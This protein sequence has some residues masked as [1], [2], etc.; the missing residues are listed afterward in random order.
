MIR[1]L[2]QQF[3]EENGM[4]NGKDD[5]VGTKNMILANTSE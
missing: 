5:R 1:E 4:W 3:E 2:R